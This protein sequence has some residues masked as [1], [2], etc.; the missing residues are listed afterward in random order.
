VNAETVGTFED[1]E[2][3]Q[4]YREHL[5]D[6]YKNPRNY[7]KSNAK[8]CSDT[9]PLCGDQITVYLETQNNKIKNITFTGDGCAISKASA[10][11]ITEYVKNKSVEEVKELNKEKVQEIIGIDPSPARVKCMMLGI[12]VIKKVL[13]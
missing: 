10:S 9:N 7:G 3:N 12:H 6:H 11:I 13:Q 5:L 8:S 1:V 2:I 4:L